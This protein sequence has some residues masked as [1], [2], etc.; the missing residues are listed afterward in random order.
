[1]THTQGK[2]HRRLGLLAL[3]AALALSACSAPGPAPFAYDL[4][5]VYFADSAL[6]TDFAAAALVAM[7]AAHP[8]LNVTYTDVRQDLIDAL[9]TNPDLAIV[10]N[11]NIPMPADFSTAVATFIDGGG[12]A[13]VADYAWT[14]AVQDALS[15]QASGQTNETTVSI[16]DDRLAVS[17]ADPLT[18]ANTGWGVYATGLTTGTGTIAAT[19]EDDRAAI[20]YTN[21]GRTAAV[22]FLNDTPSTDGADLFEN[23]FEVMMQGTALSGF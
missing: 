16:V 6:G 12:H 19:F 3:V 8:L 7:E 13:V 9:A 14:A 1:M 20:V 18:L 4:D 11:Q 22:G 2:V 17:V 5:V 10:F 15:V 23:L 21:D